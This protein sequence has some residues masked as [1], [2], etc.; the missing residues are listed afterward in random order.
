MGIRLEKV[1]VNNSDNKKILN[2]I[3]TNINSK[4]ITG[5]IG[6]SGSGKTTFLSVLGGLKMPDSGKLYINDEMFDK[7]AGK[8][9]RKKIGMVFQYPE[10]QIFSDTVFDEL[11]F[12][13]D[14]FNVPKTG[15]LDKMNEVLKMVGLS[16]SYLTAN[17]FELSSGERRKIAIASVLVYDP[18]ILIFDEVT[19]SLDSKSKENIKKL[20]VTLKNKYGKTI[21]VASHDADFLYSFVDDLIIL[22]NGSVIESGK[23]EEVFKNIRYLKTRNIPI[24][25]IVLFI[26]RVASK[27]GIKLENYDN[28]NDL[29]KAVY[30]SV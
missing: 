18:E 27:T 28:V 20:L 15:R 26:H 9:F 21:I 17:P 6:L 5:V 24:P 23:K 2:N 30:R 25:K 29:I 1:S 4:N 14:N 19:T 12:A 13:L 7:K 10:E 8:K 22:D 11:S 16:D 3:S